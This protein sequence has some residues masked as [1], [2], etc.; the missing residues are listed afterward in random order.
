MAGY[1]WLKFC[2]EYQKDLN[3][4]WYQNGKNMAELGNSDRL[5]IYANPSKSYVNPRIQVYAKSF[6]MTNSPKPLQLWI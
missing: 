3:V 5:K 4:D 6:Q 1:I 2:M